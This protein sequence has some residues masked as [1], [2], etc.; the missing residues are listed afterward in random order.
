MIDLHSHLL[1]GLDDGPPDIDGSVAMAERA[2]R[3][4]IETIVATPHVN[5]RYRNDTQTIGDALARVRGVL[6]DEQLPLEVLPGAEIAVNYLAE[7][8]TSGIGSLSLGGGEWLLI[9]PPFATVATGLVTT[10]QGLIWDGHRVVLAHP[11]R[12]PAIHRDPTIVERLADDGVLMSLTA[13]SLTGRFGSQARRMAI[14]LLREGLAHNVT[15]D[16]HDASNRPP[17]VADEIEGA[18]FGHLRAWLTEEVPAAVL[19]GGPVPPRPPDP[20]RSDLRSRVAR[21]LRRA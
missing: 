15:S 7:S 2:L 10:V 3:E 17:G 11:E 14:A 12:C 6:A 19:G 21:A 16:S 4:G 8:D 20:P 9:E 13:G 18:G 1:P 5:S